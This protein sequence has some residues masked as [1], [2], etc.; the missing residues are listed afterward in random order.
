[1]IIPHTDLC[2][3]T[4]KSILLIV[5]RVTG[6]AGSLSC[7]ALNS[8]GSPIIKYNIQPSLSLVMLMLLSHENGFSN[9]F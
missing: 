3:Q 5:F 8:I 4:G 1:M 7:R 6:L 9:F 2:S